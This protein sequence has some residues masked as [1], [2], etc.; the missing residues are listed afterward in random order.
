MLVFR[1]TAK[2]TFWMNLSDL[3]LIMAHNPTHHNQECLR[4]QGA[5]YGVPKRLEAVTVDATAD[6]AGSCGQ[7]E[8]G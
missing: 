3:R 5:S 6:K 7:G 8:S 2:V 1:V 4:R